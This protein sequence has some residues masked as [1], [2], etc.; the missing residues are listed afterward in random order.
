MPHIVYILYSQRVDSFYIGETEDM[1]ERLR[2][3]NTHEF[4]NSYTKQAS[5]W[6]LY[7][8]ISCTS[9]GQARKIEQHIKRMKSRKY[10]EN[11]QKYPE[12]AEKLLSKY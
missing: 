12:I 9:R 11:L 3:H 1:A 10:Y 4:K 7:Y 6:E 8:S 5:D 2:L